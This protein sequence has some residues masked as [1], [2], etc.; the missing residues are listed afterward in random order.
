MRGVIFDGGLPHSVDEPEPSD[1]DPGEDPAGTEAAGPCHG[2]LSA[3][4][5]L[6]AAIGIF[7]G[8]SAAV[9]GDPE[10]GDPPGTSVAG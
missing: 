10:C 5:A 4:A 1:P 3:S 8:T 9:P 2:D 6:K 7:T